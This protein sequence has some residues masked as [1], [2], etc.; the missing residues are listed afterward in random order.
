MMKI[1]LQLTPNPAAL[2]LVHI[3]HT[4]LILSLNTGHS[5]DCSSKEDFR[6]LEFVQQIQKYLKP[7]HVLLGLSSDVVIHLENLGNFIPELLL[8]NF[9]FLFISF[10]IY[11]FSIYF[12]F[13]YLLQL[14]FE[15]SLSPVIAPK[16]ARPSETGSDEVRNGS[17]SYIWL[18]F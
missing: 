4:K 10:S 14:D 6:F 7:H 16:K 2:N 12:F 1:W 5:S 11:F 17:L 8:F 13:F 9:L 3:I 15:G 18:G